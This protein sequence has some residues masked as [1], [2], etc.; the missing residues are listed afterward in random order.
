LLE[1][2]LIEKLPAGHAVDPGAHLGEAI[3]IGVLHFGLPRSHP[4][5]HIVLKREIGG[6]HHRPAR[7]DDKGPHHRPE[8]DWA[9]TDLRARM[10]KRKDAGA[11]MPRALLARPCAAVAHPGVWAWCTWCGRFCFGGE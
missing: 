6:G 11:E 1:L 2:L 4:G 7:H 5:K 10:S 8:C 9:K 3:L